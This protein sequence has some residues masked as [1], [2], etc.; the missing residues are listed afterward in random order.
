M[1][2]TYADAVVAL[3]HEVLV[4]DLY[5]MGFDPR[6]QASEIPGPEG[7]IPPPEIVNER[8]MLKDIDVFVFFYP[9][10]FGSPPAMLKGYVERVFGLGFGYQTIKAGGGGPL[11][12]G[13]KMISFTSTGSENTWLVDSGS[14]SAVRKIFD[15]R[16]ADACGLEAMDHVNFGGVDFDMDPA[17]INEA[18]A[19]VRT[20]VADLLTDDTGPDATAR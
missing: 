7:A 13:R 4:R 17:R 5:A 19:Q 11:L 9:I 18:V 20:L 8:A 14:W 1:A 15:Q 16:L 6:L 2:Q 10:W 3:G 12:T